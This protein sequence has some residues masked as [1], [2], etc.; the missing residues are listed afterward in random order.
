MHEGAST[1]DVGK[2]ELPPQLRA[3]FTEV[4]VG[5]PAARSELAALAASYL[6]D[7][8]PSPPLDAIVDFY[9]AA[10]AEAVRC[11]LPMER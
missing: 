11:L 3:R 8:V 2:R 5:E 9:L 1:A 7:A 10:K 6:A 4:W